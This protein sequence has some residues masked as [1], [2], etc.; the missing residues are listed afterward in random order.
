MGLGITPVVVP[1][2]FDEIP[3][4]TDKIPTHRCTDFDYLNLLAKEAGYV[5]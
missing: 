4:P 2:I 3:L 5:F 1:P